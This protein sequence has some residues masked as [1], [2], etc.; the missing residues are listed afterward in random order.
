MF[1]DVSVAPR[2]TTVAARADRRFWWFGDGAPIQEEEIYMKHAWL[3]LALGAGIGCSGRGEWGRFPGGRLASHGR[4]NRRFNER[5]RIISG[6]RRHTERR[7]ACIWRSAGSGRSI[8]WGSAL[9]RGGRG[10]R[11]PCDCRRAQRT[12]RSPM[13]DTRGRGALFFRHDTTANRNDAG[14]RSSSAPTRSRCVSAVL[15]SPT[16]L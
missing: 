13:Q 15:L 11:R 16:H 2:Y 10:E 7:N 9:R 12:H 5:R 8:V 1:D 6:V 4:P 3:G 14:R